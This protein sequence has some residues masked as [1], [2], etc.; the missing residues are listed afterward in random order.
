MNW[1]SLLGARLLSAGRAGKPVALR[2]CRL[3]L[4]DGPLLGLIVHEDLAVPADTEPMPEHRDSLTGLPD[5]TFLVVA[6]DGVDGWR[7]LG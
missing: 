4:A 5:R 7:T 1:M 6:N 3:P 2:L